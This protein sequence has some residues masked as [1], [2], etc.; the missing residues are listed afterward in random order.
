MDERTNADPGSNGKRKVNR[1]I[2]FVMNAHK[3]MKLRKY[4]GPRE[5]KKYIARNTTD[6]AIGGAARSACAGR[7]FIVRG[8]ERR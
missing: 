4:T 5:R 2:V 7:G 6:S 3:I 8:Q 1:V